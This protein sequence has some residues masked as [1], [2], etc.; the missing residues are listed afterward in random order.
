M[1]AA[2]VAVFVG[3]EFDSITGRGRKEGELLRKTPWGELAW[4]LGG[5]EPEPGLTVQHVDEIRV[6]LR[7]L[8][9]SGNVIIFRITHVPGGS[10]SLTGVFVDP[11]S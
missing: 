3:T 7:E 2:E 4:Q 11:A 5:M 6:A 1:P 8:D 10:V 9:I